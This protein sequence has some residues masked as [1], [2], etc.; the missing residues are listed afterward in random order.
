MFKNLIIILIDGGRL[1]WAKKFPTFNYLKSKSIFFPNSVTYAPYTTSAV[2]ALFSGCYGNRT[3]VDSYWHTFRFQKN[4]FLTITEYLRNNGYYTYA[5]GHTELIA[6]KQGLD[7]FNIHD[8]LTA[9]LPRHHTQL[10]E[11][12]NEKNEAGQPFFLYLHYSKIHTTIMN[13]VLKVYT[14]FTEEYFKNRDLN[15][16]RYDNIFHKADDYLQIILKKIEDLGLDENSIILVLS[17]HGISIGEKFGE[18]A[19]GAF[20]YDYTIRT[21]AYLYSKEF[22]AKEITQQV[23]Q[24]DFMPTILEHLGISLDPNYEKLD[25]ESLIPLIRG[26]KIDEKI[27]FSETGNPLENKAPPKIPNTKSV[28]TSKWKLIFNEYNNSKELYNLEIDPEE[29]HNVIGMN[30]EIEDFLWNEYKKI[31]SIE[32]SEN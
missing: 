26:E 5:D 1:D 17:D 6:P 27:A 13:E 29:T 22:S 30:K 16:R 2:H 15:E 12:M 21:F 28:R 7:E 19:Y 23:R 20:C 11:N 4:K 24:V 3:G 8:E 31:D 14:N 9:D 10:L 18:R 32:R 25:G